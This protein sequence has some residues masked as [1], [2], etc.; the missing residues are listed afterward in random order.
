MGY[1]PSPQSFFSPRATSASYL[2]PTLDIRHERKLAWENLTQQKM[3]YGDAPS[4]E[5]LLNETQRMWVALTA[6]GTKNQAPFAR[7]ASAVDSSSSKR[8]H[9]LVA[10]GFT[11][12]F[13]RVGIVSVC[14]DSRVVDHDTLKVETAITKVQD[15]IDLV[16]FC[17]TRGCA[18][19]DLALAQRCNLRNKHTETAS[20]ETALDT[21]DSGIELDG[22]NNS[23][24]LATGEVA[25]QRC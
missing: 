24:G 19:Q 17:K 5:L 18:A 1:T 10:V 21:M 23:N 11:C 3:H 4:L 12:Q 9:F 14:W 20:F 22:S 13:T 25:L 6:Q 15:Q 8:L 16:I 7:A 2:Y